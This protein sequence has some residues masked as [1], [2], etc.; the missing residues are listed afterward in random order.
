MGLFRKRKKDQTVDERTDIEKSFEEAGQKAGIETGKFVQKSV[1]KIN[2]LREK[3]DA[4]EK[5]DKV[6]EFAG[7]AEK[8]ADELVERATQRGK[9]VIDKVKGK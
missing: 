2:E 1:D 9:E 3:Y 6:K 4:D 5:I 7:K 8:K